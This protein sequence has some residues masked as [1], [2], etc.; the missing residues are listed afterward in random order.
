MTIYKD[1]M[2]SNKKTP[3]PSQSSSPCTI[4]VQTQYSSSDL[5]GQK[6]WVNIEAKVTAEPA[7]KSGQTTDMAINTSELIIYI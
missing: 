3:C 7:A 2:T 4:D 6:Y 5:P 1:G